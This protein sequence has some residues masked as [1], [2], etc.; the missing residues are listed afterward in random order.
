MLLVTE[1]GYGRILTMSLVGHYGTISSV[2]I[3]EQRKIKSE[4]TIYIIY[5]KYNI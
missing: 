1:K 2:L 3:S 5:M 4:I